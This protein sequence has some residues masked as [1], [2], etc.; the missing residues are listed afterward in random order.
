MDLSDTNQSKPRPNFG[1]FML[2]KNFVICIIF[3]FIFIGQAHAGQS[4]QERELEENN[5]SF[6]FDRSSEWEICQGYNTRNISHHGNL[7]YSF[8]FA[9]GS[10]NSGQTGCLH[11][12]DRSENELVLSPA[13]GKIVWNGAT[14]T[15]IT[16]LRL[17]KPVQ[18]GYGATIRSL[19]IG[20]LKNSHGRKQKDSGVERGE[21]IGV[22]C[23]ST[24]SSTEC[25]S[26]GGYAHIHINAH[27]DENCGT[28]NI[29]PFGTAFNDYD[30]HSDGTEYQWHKKIIQAI[31]TAREK[32]AFFRIVPKSDNTATMSVNFI[33]PDGTGLIEIDDILILEE[34]TRLSELS[35]APDGSKISF[36]YCKNPYTQYDDD[37][38][39]L[40]PVLLYLVNSDG[41][42]IRRLEIPSTYDVTGWLAMDTPVWSPDAQKIAFSFSYISSKDD[43]SSRNSKS[44]RSIYVINSDGTKLK[45]LADTFPGATSYK[46][47][48]SPDG[49]KIAYTNHTDTGW[50]IHVIKADGTSLAKLTGY[51]GKY[52]RQPIWSPTEDKIAFISR[53]ID[54][55]SSDGKSII[56]R[57]DR[58]DV[59]NADGTG[60]IPLTNLKYSHIDDIA[61]S[62]D[63]QRLAYSA[64]Y[65]GIPRIVVINAD[66]SG[67]I[68]LTDDSVEYVDWYSWSPDGGNIIARLKRDGNYR[69]YLLSVENTEKYI[70]AD[71]FFTNSMDYSW[72]PDGEKI[73]FCF[74]S[75]SY[76]SINTIK[77]DGT[78]LTKL[79]D[80]KGH[81]VGPAWSP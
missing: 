72:S 37:L 23:G 27:T 55:Y 71:D 6:P 16:C 68:K 10:E 48:W 42:V 43:Y 65:D 69:I 15:D 31:Q 60:R 12:P 67:K 21:V 22:L 52:D 7:V 39:Y 44:K 35:W 80:E 36:M 9:I 5:L 8:D 32:I 1:V 19:K 78:D 47:S 63:G 73:A 2:K 58:I 54:K 34:N 49:K 18:N 29:A 20:H 81:D 3:C 53:P 75:D 59:I 51:E 14:H 45:K 33:N 64:S 26:V 79:T 17:N 41:S 70:F 61:W 25:Q 11:H 46:F 76:A 74:E 50:R 28:S 38:K 77:T 62:P 4:Q 24:F 66:G 13:D 30:F 40:H 57:V 56:D